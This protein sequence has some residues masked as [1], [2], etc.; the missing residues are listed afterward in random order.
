MRSN[1]KILY[2]FVLYGLAASTMSHLADL[3]YAVLFAD[4]VSHN[5]SFPAIVVSIFLHP[6]MFVPTAWPIIGLLN[7][8]LI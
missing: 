3:S 5:T 8:L 4:G 7:Y 1:R 2:L 6:F